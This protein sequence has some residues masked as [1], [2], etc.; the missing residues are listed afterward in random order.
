MQKETLHDG[1]AIASDK[2]SPEKAISVTAAKLSFAAAAACLILLAVLHVI[3]PEF[4][5]SWRFVSE[6][7]IGHYG[8]VMT[9]SFLAM[10]ISCVALFATVRSQV[11]TIGGKI[12]LVLLLANAVGFA[13]AAIFTTDPITASKE[14]LTTHG[15]L[16]EVGYLLKR[17]GRLSKSGL[18]LRF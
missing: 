4:G 16:H 15:K 11:R 17:S 13:I 6:Y 18:N 3:E 12:G 14:V 7:A 8:R 5:P 1:T 10:A 2:M 9:L